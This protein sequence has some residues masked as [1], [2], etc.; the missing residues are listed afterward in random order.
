MTCQPPWRDTN[1]AKAKLSC[2][3]SCLSSNC[4]E[5]DAPGALLVR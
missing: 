3:L 4:C 2:R 1:K 5:D